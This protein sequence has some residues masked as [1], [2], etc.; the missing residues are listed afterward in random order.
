MFVAPSGGYTYQ[1]IGSVA[2]RS[3]CEDL[4]TGLGAIDS[5]ECW[6]ITYQAISQTCRLISGEAMLTWAVTCDWFAYDSS[7]ETFQRI[8][9]GEKRKAVV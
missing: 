6:M 2:S 7:W 4:C 9:F 5:D 3:D 1:E 8:C